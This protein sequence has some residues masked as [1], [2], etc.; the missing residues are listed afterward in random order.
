MTGPF[1]HDVGRD[2]PGDGLDD[3]GLAA[4]MGTDQCPFRM[5]FIKTGAA[6][7][8]GD[9]YRL[10]DSG[11]LAKLL[12]FAVHRQVGVLGKDTVVLHRYRPVF[13]QKATGHI[14]DFN[15]N[16]VGG[17]DSGDLQM[18]GFDVGPAQGLG[19]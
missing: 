11:H 19:I 17:L 9:A 16:A 7:V 2:A 6:L 13:L 3:E 5:D 10:V 14:V 4:G 8:C 12:E 1:H 15:L 18:V